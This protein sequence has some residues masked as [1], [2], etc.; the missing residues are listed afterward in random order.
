[1]EALNIL[2]MAERVS[3]V[4]LD[5]GEGAAACRAQFPE[6]NWRFVPDGKETEADI[7]WANVITGHPRPMW[8]KNAENLRWLHIQSAGVNGYERREIYAD[9]G[10]IVTRAAGVHAPAMAEHALGLALSLTRRLP[11]LYRNQIAGTWKPVH[12]TKNLHGATAVLL[13]TGWLAAD[14]V[15]L[16][17]P[18]G[19]RILG[20]RRDIG[21]GTPEGYDEV[22]PVSALHEA[23][24]QA[25]YI[26]S[27]LPYTEATRK[28]M[29]AAAFDAVKPGAVF[30]NMGRGGTVDT[31]ALM[32]A[33]E[34]GKLGG[35]GLDVTDPEPLPDGHP[36]WRAP[37]LIITPHCSAWSDLTDKRRY[38]RFLEL[39]GMFLNGEELPGQI[40]FEAGY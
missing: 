26:F 14:L 28:L 35:A 7:R 37:N 9:P 22:Y 1:M 33:L 13:G 32:A 25:D 2:V 5:T 27:T 39:L 12:A 11:D 29:D 40:D 16:L 3:N 23:L 15:P 36:L 4:M 10:P 31:D 30:I 21:K 24:A 17:K 6:M 18:F 20:V 8:L 38:G 34:S 19:C